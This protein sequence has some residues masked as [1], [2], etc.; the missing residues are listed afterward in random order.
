[1]TLTFRQMPTG[2]E[3]RRNWLLKRLRDTTCPAEED[4][5][6]SESVLLCVCVGFLTSR[7]MGRDYCWVVRCNLRACVCSSGRHHQFSISRLIFQQV[8]LVICP[9]GLPTPQ[10]P[11]KLQ[12]SMFPVAFHKQHKVWEIMTYHTHL[13]WEYAFLPNVLKNVQ[14]L[15]SIT[16]R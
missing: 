6:F 2:S 10:Q 11:W 12:H 8:V 14:V 16:Y 9:S 13:Q 5:G 4:K 1:M 7:H 15:N 3:Q